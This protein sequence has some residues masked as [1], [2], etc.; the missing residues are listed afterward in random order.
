M[1]M[2]PLSGVTLRDSLGDDGAILFSFCRNVFEARHEFTRRDIAH[3]S[4]Y[5]QNQMRVFGRCG[6]G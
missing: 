4:C 1:P 5:G 2:S 3:Q 6:G